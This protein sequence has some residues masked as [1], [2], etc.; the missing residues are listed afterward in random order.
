MK[1]MKCLIIIMS[2]VLVLA[3]IVNL[4]FSLR[5][6]ESS[7]IYSIIVDFFLAGLFTLTIIFAFLRN[8]K[9][10]NRIMLALVC[11]FPLFFLSSGIVGIVR[12]L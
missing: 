12:L 9:N 3:T 4:V 5:S 6:G 2:V 1:G 8:H 11:V 7:A 10:D